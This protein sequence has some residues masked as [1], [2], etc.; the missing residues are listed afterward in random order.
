[1][2]S[3]VRHNPALLWLDLVELLE[4]AKTRFG[5]PRDLRLSPT[6]RRAGTTMDGKADKYPPRIQ[7]RLYRYNRPNQA[8]AVS[9]VMAILAHELAHFVKGGW[10]HGP[11]HRR[12][13]REVAAWIREQGYPV[14]TQLFAGTGRN[15]IKKRVR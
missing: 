9:T 14:S 3:T 8:F 10:D 13:T 1:M 11:E 5:L 15:R 4:A 7:L 2:N 12:I 6:R